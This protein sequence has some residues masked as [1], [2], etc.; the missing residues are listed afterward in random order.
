MTRSKKALTACAFT[1]ALALGSA[2]PAL[3][4]SYPGAAT[5]ASA[6]ESSTQDSYPGS[7]DPGAA[8]DQ[9]IDGNH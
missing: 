9:V 4:D 8:A 7:P 2:A 5:G 6:S 1:A 3:A